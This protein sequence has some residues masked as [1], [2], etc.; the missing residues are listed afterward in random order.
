MCKKLKKIIKATS[1]TAVALLLIFSLIITFARDENIPTWDDIFVSVGLKERILPKSAEDYVVFFD[2]GQGDSALIVSNGKTALIDTGE[3]QY[4]NLLYNKLRVYGAD[5][6]DFM[7]G[8]HIHSDHIGGFSYILDNMP[9]KNLM[10]NFKNFDSDAQ[11]DLLD[12]IS[13]LCKMHKVKTFNPVRA[14]VVNIGDFEITVIGFY[15]NTTGE[16]NRSIFT[17]AKIGDHKFLFT[18]D[19]EKQAEKLLLKDNINI[20]CD[21]LKVAH[22]GSKTSTNSD[23]IDAASPE[24][25]VISCGSDNQYGHPDKDTIK[26]LQKHNVK[27]LRTDVNSDIAFEISDKGLTLFT[28]KQ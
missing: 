16:N 8:S 14:S 19:A 2:V 28:E 24:Y 9:V 12:G 5:G 22:H 13:S 11:D 23:F 3:V 15:P 1:F 20:D 21:V 26:D 7:L 25:A 6:I 10:L 4:G 17:M 18:G 27:I